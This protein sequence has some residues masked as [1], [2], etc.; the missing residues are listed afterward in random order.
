MNGQVELTNPVD[1]SIGGM[2]GHLLRRGIHLSMSLLPFIYFAYGEHV[3]DALGLSLDQVVASVL[4]VAMTGEGIRLRLGFT[5]FGQRDYEANQ[6]SALAWGAIGV[7]MVFLLAPTE[8]YAWPLILSLSL[9]DPLMGELRRKGMASRNVMLVSTLALLAIWLVAWAQ[10]G[11]P[12]W[13]A[14][15]LAPVCMASEWPR[16][17]YIDDNATMVLIP[18]ALVLILEP[19]AGVMA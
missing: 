5:V 2:R 17:T 12:L 16:L 19:F 15:L 8:A 10:F 4:L 9:G 11:T 18:L 14:L 13:M 6:I 1:T 7:G 3:A